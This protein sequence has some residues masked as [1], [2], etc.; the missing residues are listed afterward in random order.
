MEARTRIER[1]GLSPATVDAWYLAGEPIPVD[2]IRC[3]IVPRLDGALVR[4]GEPPMTANVRCSSRGN[5]CRQLL[6][7][8]GAVH[9]TV[10]PAGN[11]ARVQLGVEGT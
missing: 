1:A 9:G 5:R 2:R 8:V 11:G 4:T 3:V 6:V 10:S 7:R